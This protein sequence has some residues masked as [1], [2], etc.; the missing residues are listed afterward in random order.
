MPIGSEADLADLRID[1]VLFEQARVL[2]VVD[3]V[4]QLLVG[5]VRLVVIASIADS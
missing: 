5:L 1:P 2:F 4:G 3:V